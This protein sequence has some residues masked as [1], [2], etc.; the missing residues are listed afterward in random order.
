MGS[1]SRK[2][3]TTIETAKGTE[4]TAARIDVIARGRELHSESSGNTATLRT[5][6]DSRKPVTTI[7]NSK[8]YRNNGSPQGCHNRK[9]V[10][11]ILKQ[12]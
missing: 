11:A 6:S 2:P 9:Q 7:R 5:G 8:G 3:V 1:D 12:S 4:T 10:A